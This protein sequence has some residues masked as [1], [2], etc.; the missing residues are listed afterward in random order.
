MLLSYDNNDIFDKSL[1]AIAS[2]LFAGHNN[3]LDS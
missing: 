1:L 3:C 2:A